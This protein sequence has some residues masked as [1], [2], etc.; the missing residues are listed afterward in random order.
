[1]TSG[2]DQPLRAIGENR[3]VSRFRGLAGAALTPSVIL[4][5]GDD[6]AAIRP[7]PG[8]LLLLTC[9]MMVEQVHFR[10]DWATPEQIGW[11]AMAQNISDIA[12]MGGQPAAAVASLAA[13]SD[14][15]SDV[16]EQI[17][18]GLIA[19]AS[20]Y[21][22]ALVGGDLVGSPGPLVIDVALAGWVEEEL[23]LRRRGARPGDSILVTGALGASAAGLGVLQRG[24]R[25]DAS[26]DIARALRAHHT[27]RPRVIEARAIAE[28]RLATAMM[29]LSDGLA[30]DLPRLCAES[31]VGA[32]IHCDRL[33]VDPACRALAAGIGK[34]AL[35]MATTGGEDYE[36]LLTCPPSAVEALKT[37]VSAH[38]N[39]PLTVIGEIVEG[40][41]VT[42]LDAKRQP[43]SLGSGFDHFAGR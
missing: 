15:P 5:P 23:M 36:L 3:T 34:T 27:P 41:S 7:E 12:A 39:A 6:A 2:P 38:S 24:I 16:P 9:D 25:D 43:V 11:K 31:S 14:L 37:A 22:A 18:S 30:D 32:R 17:A 19:A 28:S 4:G 1:M 21:G 10:R 8:R 29:D 26:P 13:P 33:P 35:E 40:R 20:E 42:F